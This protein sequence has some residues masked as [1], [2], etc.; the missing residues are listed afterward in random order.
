MARHFNAPFDVPM[1]CSLVSSMKPSQIPDRH[2]DLSFG[3]MTALHGLKY[4]CSPNFG[5]SGIDGSD[6]MRCLAV[7][8]SI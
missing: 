5:I 1:M 3:M 8:P 4:T 6:L 7:L 2:F